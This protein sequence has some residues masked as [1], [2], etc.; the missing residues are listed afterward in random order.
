MRLV[1][2]MLVTAGLLTAGCGWSPP[3]AAP[4]K[5]DTCTPADGP[6]P[7]TVQRE[8]RG[9]P[10]AGTAWTEVGNGHTT[11]CRLYWVQIG[12][13]GPQPDSPQQVLFFAGD[14]PLGP[15]T[16]QPRPYISVLPTGEDTVTVQY[17]W[18]QGDEAPCCPTG[19]G[20]VRF[21]LG[22][23]GKLEAVDPIPN[24]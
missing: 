15:A 21:K 18:R 24:G 14:T 20:T 17:Q 11:D 19:I 13:G 4:P 23:D 6:T 9:A 7:D 22:Q 12:T 10:P 2:T 1:L 5:P 3:G 8:I 16:P